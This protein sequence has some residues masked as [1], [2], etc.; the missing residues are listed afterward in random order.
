MSEKYYLVIVKCGHLGF[1]RSV[2]ITR[3]FKDYNVLNVYFSAKEMPRS[4]KHSTSVVRVKEITY[5]EYLKGKEEEKEN[6]YLNTCA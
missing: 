4:K 5:C 3:Y 2:E 1:G 6:P